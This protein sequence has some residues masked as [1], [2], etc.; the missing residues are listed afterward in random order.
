MS[1]GNCSYVTLAT[2]TLVEPRTN[3]SYCLYHN[4]SAPPG[5]MLSVLPCYPTSQACYNRDPQQHW[6]YQAEDQSI[7]PFDHRGLCLTTRYN[8]GDN[9]PYLLACNGTVTQ[10]WSFFGPA[11]GAVGWGW[12]QFGIGVANL[13]VIAI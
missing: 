3:V 12:L 10:H 13:G 6:V 11:P 2:E 1:S 7:R 9:V 5:D 4:V 8:Y